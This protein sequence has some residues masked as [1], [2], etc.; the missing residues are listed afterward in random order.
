[1]SQKG[2]SKIWIL[3]VGVLFLMGGFLALQYPKTKLAH[4]EIIKKPT[5]Y[6]QLTLT[7]PDRK[8][9]FQPKLIYRHMH[10]T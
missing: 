2:F 10:L 6:T 7:F 1:M 8:I 4:D 9:E 3:V 5:E